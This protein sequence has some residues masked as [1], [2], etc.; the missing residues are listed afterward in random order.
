MPKTKTPT[1]DN[2]YKKCFSVTMA[3]LHAYEKEPIAP[4][5]IAVF[6]DQHRPT[7]HWASTPIQPGGYFSQAVFYYADIQAILTEQHMP[8][9]DRVKQ[10]NADLTHANKAVRDH[11]EQIGLPSS[12]ATLV[13][14]FAQ[15]D[16]LKSFKQN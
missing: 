3:S 8:K 12:A 10:L 11:L 9:G 15:T 16:A 2:I 5:V 1:L 6:S 13:K 7:D 4:E 14:Y